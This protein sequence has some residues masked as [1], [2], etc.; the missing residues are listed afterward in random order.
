PP[1]YTTNFKAKEVVFTFNEYLQLKDVQK[2]I[3]ISPPIAPRP[4]FAVKGKSIVMKFPPEL[5]LDSNTTYRVDFG[6]SIQ[7]NNEGNPA[8]RFEYIFSTGNKIDSL[9]M[10]GKLVDAL[11][12]ADIVNGFVLYYADERIPNDT[13]LSDSTI[14]K[15]KKLGIA[16]T[17]STGNFLTRNLKAIPYRIFGIKDENGNQEYDMG[18]DMV[19][20]SNARYNPETMKEFD[21]WVD[22]VKDR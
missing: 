4:I 21:V 13:L 7:D 1:N 11:T 6:N 17:D 20:L 19:G 16:R 10:S 15:G 18:G 8:K 14:F 5:K 9:V 12:G 3:L 2:E 22:P